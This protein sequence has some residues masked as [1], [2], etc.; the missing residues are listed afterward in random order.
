MSS[1]PLLTV[2]MPTFNGAAFLPAA[3]QSVLRQ[4]DG[5]PLEIIV[6][7]DGSTDETL[8]ILESFQRQLPLTIERRPRVG[9]WVANTNAGIRQAR[10]DYVAFLHQDDMWLPERLT[11]FQRLARSFPRTGVFLNP[12]Y[13]ID[14]R[15]R[16]VGWWRC[17]LPANR[18]LEPA[19]WFRALC[20]QNYI[21]IPAPI[22]RRDLL[23]SVGALDES[24]TY[25]ADWKLWLELAS[26]SGAVRANRATTCFRVHA[27]SQTS[28]AVRNLAAYRQQQERVLTAYQPALARLPGAGRWLKAARLSIEV[29][30]WLAGYVNGQRPRC[31]QLAIECLKAGPLATATYWRA[32]RIGERLGARLR[33][34]LRAAPAPA[35]S[36]FTPGGPASGGQ[37]SGS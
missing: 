24:L 9:N 16:Q 35:A 10:G 6:L 20:V 17:P 11:V 29:N 3:L 1:P 36:G 32:S 34:G 7:D 14:A 12:S 18:P 19:R 30:L 15:G 27:Q 2:I 25:T 21:A 8:A 5:V 28:G 22:V 26:R 13:F 33:A 37:S 4:T 31:R 23:E